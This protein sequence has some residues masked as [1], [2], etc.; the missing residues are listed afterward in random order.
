[1]ITIICIGFVTALA[2]F[3]IA[4]KTCKSQP[5]KLQ[6]WEKADIM[7]Q[8]LTLSERENGIPAVGP[9]RSKTTQRAVPGMRPGELPRKVT[10]RISQPA[11]SAQ[12]RC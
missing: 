4:L 10:S 3:V 12:G 8:L 6:K 11:P 5:K 2:G 7:K 9:S 1:M